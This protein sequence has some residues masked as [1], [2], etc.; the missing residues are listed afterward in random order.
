MEKSKKLS[1]HVEHG[2]PPFVYEEAEILI[3]GS[4]PS[5]VSRE[6]GFYYGHPRNRFWSVLAKVYGEDVPSGIEDK[7]SFLKRH[8]I[9]LW[10]VVE[11]C[12]IIGASDSS[13]TNVAPNDIRKIIRETAI[14]KICVTGKTAGKLL[15]KYVGIEGIE[16]PSPSPANCAASFDDLV[17]VYEVALSVCLK[18][19]YK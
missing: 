4:F 19:P 14:G 15:K 11:S 7:K 2:F 5:P 10:D 17:K 13:I 12:D 9:A 1:K 16:L 3:L 18:T 6:T 8:K